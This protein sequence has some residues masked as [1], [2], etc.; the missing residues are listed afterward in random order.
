MIDKILKEDKHL[1]PI[2]KSLTY[3]QKKIIIEDFNKQNPI[4][5]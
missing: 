1:E 3:D 5:Q 2:F 4:N